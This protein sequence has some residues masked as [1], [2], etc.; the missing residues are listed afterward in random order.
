MSSSYTIL[1]YRTR[2]AV[3]ALFGI[4]CRCETPEEV[5]AIG[6]TRKRVCERKLEREQRADSKR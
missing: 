1:A 2:E 4:V 6:A 3:D 5:L